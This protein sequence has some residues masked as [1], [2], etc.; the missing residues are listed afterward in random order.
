M[1]IYLQVENKLTQKQFDLTTYNDL[2]IQ[3][4]Y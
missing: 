2:N 1:D 3:I 4:K